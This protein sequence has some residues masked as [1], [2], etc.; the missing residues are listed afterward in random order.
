VLLINK[1]PTNKKELAM[2]TLF[3]SLSALLLLFFF[4]CQEGNIT[5]PVQDGR[6]EKDYNTY[7]NTDILELE[8]FIYDPVHRPNIKQN[9]EVTGKVIY[10]HTLV[11]LDPA[12][13]APQVY[14]L[15]EVRL[16]M[17]I[18]V[19][20]PKG[21]KIWSVNKYFE[22][23]VEISNINEIEASFEKRFVVE[24]ACCHPCDMLFRFRVTEKSLEVESM[25]LERTDTEF[26]NNT[27][28]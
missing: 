14:V 1:T 9:A 27:T 22:E 16:N 15:L 8:G 23:R 13:P 20:C 19:Q 3:V 21:E 18:K 6:A 12:P 11:R 24:N 17:D 2:K 4:A 25:W 26:T 28:W 7:L 5:D 10:E